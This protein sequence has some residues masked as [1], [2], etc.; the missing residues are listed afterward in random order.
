MGDK[1]PQ[2]FIDDLLSRVD[3]V[4]VI[5]ARVP[6]KKAGNS[7]KGLCPFHSEKTPS[8]N[9]S[10]QKQF[11]HCFGCGVSGNAIGFLMEHDRLGFREAVEEL[12]GL[13]GIRLPTAHEVD[14]SKQRSLAELYVQLETVARH[15]RHQLKHHPE[16]QRAIDY[17]K[18]RGLSG[19]VAAEYEI[20]FAPPG[21]NGLREKFGDRSATVKALADGGM[22][23]S[24]DDGE[25]EDRN[26]YD[27]FRDRI[28]FPIRDKRGRVVGFGGRVLGEGTPK[29]LN[30][31]ETE[32]FHKGRELYG[33]YQARKAQR[34]FARIVVVEGYMDVVG[35]AQF[36]IRYA[37]ATLGTALTEYNLVELSRQ[38]REIVFCFDGDR[39]G[40]QAAWKALEVSLPSVHDSLE[41]RFMFLPDGEDPDTAVRRFGREYFEQQ[42]EAARPL[43][44]FFFDTLIAQADMRGLDGQ[45]RLVDMARPLLGK[46]PRGAFRDLMLARLGQV[47]GLAAGQ[48]RGALSLQAET[49]SPANPQAAPVAR[50]VNAR[51][52]SSPVKVALALVLEWPEIAQHAGEANRFEEL[53][54]P[55]IRL[56][57][58]MLEFLQAHPQLSTGAIL[59]NWRG[60]PEGE[61]LARL[62]QW[63]HPVPREGAQE[64]FL[65][66]LRLLDELLLEQRTERLLQKSKLAPLT[67]EEKKQL[68]ALLLS[69]QAKTREIIG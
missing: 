57:Q 39:A 26:W 40:R 29:Y 49:P 64:E 50:R 47:V 15:Y 51:G 20:G 21:W 12:A 60:T 42:V 3:I 59:E 30:S 1:I 24:K 69:G 66:T 31:P 5:D 9:V 4:S 14:P 46:L 37:V 41:L 65:G 35:L 48:L 58:S 18:S 33:L 22:L 68:Q 54:I 63:E 36:G 2:E 8:F 38:T 17:L 67:V 23:V 45:A 62:A 61:S 28:M 7:H 52:V 25:Q 43:S 32:I 13:V 6:L 56:L 16:H 19:E 44:E 34:E 53:S 27:R 11:Y 10:S 55:G